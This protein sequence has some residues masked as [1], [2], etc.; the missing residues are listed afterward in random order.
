[1]ERPDRGDLVGPGVPKP[2]VAEGEGPEDDGN[3]TDD[4]HAA[5]RLVVTHVYARPM[6]AEKCWFVGQRWR[7]SNRNGAA[8]TIKLEVPVYLLRELVRTVYGNRHSRLRSY[9]RRLAGV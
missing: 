5:L 8:G 6:P 7:T 9:E 2:A 4:F 1:M 3:D